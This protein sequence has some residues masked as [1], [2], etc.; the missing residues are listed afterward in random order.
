MSYF[1]NF[2][3]TNNIRKYHPGLPTYIQVG[4]HQYIEIAL[5]C[6]WRMDMLFGW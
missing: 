4:E 3:V 5:I 1:N 6:R 2:Q